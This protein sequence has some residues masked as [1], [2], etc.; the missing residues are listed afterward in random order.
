M[1]TLCGICDLVENAGPRLQI[2]QDSLRTP[3]VEMQGHSGRVPVCGAAGIAMFSSVICF[4]H[5][6]ALVGPL[7]PRGIPFFV[8]GM[9]RTVVKDL[10]RTVGTKTKAVNK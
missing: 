8:P 9:L 2:G 6:K 10:R 4:D 5:Q 1:F 3:E 7:D